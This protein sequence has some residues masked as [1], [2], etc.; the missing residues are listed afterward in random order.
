MFSL[1]DIYFPWVPSTPNHPLWTPQNGSN[2]VLGAS[3]TP[4][5]HEVIPDPIHPSDGVDSI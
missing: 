3:C 5:N 4:F 2:S 1:N